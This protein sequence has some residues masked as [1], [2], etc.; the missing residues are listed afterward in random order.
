MS[1]P[2]AA[3]PAGPPGTR[4]SFPWRSRPAS[5]R[6][7]PATWR[8]CREEAGEGP[9]GRRR[10][11]STRAFW[12]SSAAGAATAAAAAEKLGCPLA[13]TLAPLPPPAS[14]PPGET[15]F[16]SPTGAPAAEAEAAAEEEG[17][18]R[19]RTAPPTSASSSSATSTRRSTT[20][21]CAT[22]W[23]RRW[24]SRTARSAPRPSSRCGWSP[25]TGGTWGSS[26]WA[27]RRR[28]TGASRSPSWRRLRPPPT[29]A[30]APTASWSERPSGR[31]GCSPAAGARLPRA[32]LR[33]GSRS[34]GCL[35]RL[36]EEE[37]D[38]AAGRT[39]TRKGGSSSSR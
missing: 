25:T 14:T 29:P 12:R 8:G 1:A 22:R 21:R 10:T 6:S 23:R 15:C 16:A 28:G 11:T 30:A 7:T 32:C 35:T 24:A 3:S 17:P 2:R 5:R 4:S 38:R 31:C 13:P 34:R 20:R 19:R 18:P 36:E 26:R 39:R 27:R 37:E 9:K 33:G